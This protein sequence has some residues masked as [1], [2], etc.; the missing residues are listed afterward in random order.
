MNLHPLFS[1]LYS[2]ETFFLLASLAILLVFVHTKYD[3]SYWPLCFYS[4]LTGIPSRGL[5]AFV[6][7][8]FMSELYA[9]G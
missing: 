1:Q 7:C 2:P 6:I 9:S 5:N 8:K 4:L 3:L